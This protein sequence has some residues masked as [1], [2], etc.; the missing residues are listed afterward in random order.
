MPANRCSAGRFDG[1]T[2]LH[3]AAIRPFSAGHGTLEDGMPDG[4][5]MH[6]RKGSSANPF[7]FSLGFAPPPTKAGLGE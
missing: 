4:I 1:N 3:R 6:P 2:G 7:P 5:R